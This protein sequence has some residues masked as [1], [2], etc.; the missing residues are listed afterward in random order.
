MKQQ[1]I[2]LIKEYKEL[3]NKR[4][5][6]DQINH[7]S[8]ETMGY[9]LEEKKP[10]N[11]NLRRAKVF[12]INEPQE[13]DNRGKF[14]VVSIGGRKKYMTATEILEKYYINGKKK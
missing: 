13:K 10:Y 9:P 5:V 3:V 8:I 1:I 4:W 11:Y 7:Y 14:L 6:L 2:R 12:F